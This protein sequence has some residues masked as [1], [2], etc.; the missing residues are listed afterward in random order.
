MRMSKQCNPEDTEELFRTATNALSMMLNNGLLDL[1]L[2]DPKRALI[3]SEGIKRGAIKVLIDLEI[4]AL[5]TNKIN[6][7]IIGPDGKKY[8][9][10]N[11]GEERTFN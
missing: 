9:L 10:F 7:K 3:I 5:D 6:F 8:P 1:E 4:S 11:F 2:E